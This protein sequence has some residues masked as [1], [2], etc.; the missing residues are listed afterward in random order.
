MV[1]VADGL[2]AWLVALL[3][4]AGRKCLTTVALGSDQERAPR[5]AATAAVE[6]TTGTCA[7]MTSELSSWQWSS[8]RCSVSRCPDASMSGQTAVPEALQAGIAQQLAH[9]GDRNLTSTGQSSA[10]VLGVSAAVLAAKLTGHLVRDI[11]VRGSSGA[12]LAP[13]AAQLD[14]DKTLLQGQRIGHPRSAGQRGAEGAGPGWT[15]GGGGRE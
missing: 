10:D 14:Y 1:F 12:P 4:H 3:A 2:G 9:L 7:Q 8:A 13:L 11:V 15:S 5:Q 6:L